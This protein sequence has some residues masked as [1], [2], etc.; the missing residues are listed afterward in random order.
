MHRIDSINDN[1]RAIGTLGQGLGLC[2]CVRALESLSL[3]ALPV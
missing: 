2:L 1:T 3:V